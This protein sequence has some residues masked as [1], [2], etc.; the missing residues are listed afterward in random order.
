[1]TKLEQIKEALHNYIDPDCNHPEQE[2]ITWLIEQLEKANSLI[3]D[4]HNTMLMVLGYGFEGHVDP[5]L[6]RIRLESYLE[7]VTQ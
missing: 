3:S 2:N 1:M 4:A 6:T 5:E 7:E